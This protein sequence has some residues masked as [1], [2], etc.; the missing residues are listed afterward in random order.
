MV[1]PGDEST[2]DERSLKLPES[3]E[4][5][6][7]RRRYPLW[8]ISSVCDFNVILG[9]EAYQILQE[10]GANGRMICVPTA[11]RPPA[12]LFFPL[13]GRRTPA[14]GTFSKGVERIAAFH[15]DVSLP[16]T[17]D[18]VSMSGCLVLLLSQRFA[19]LNR[20]MV[21]SYTLNPSWRSASVE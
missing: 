9:V 5:Q 7:L 13:L 14:T 21:P 19:F 3:P 12:S 20:I 8:S 6:V 16:L 10:L 2:E 17:H 18:R 15:G 4:E 1:K 11:K